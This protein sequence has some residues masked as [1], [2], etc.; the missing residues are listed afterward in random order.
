M[1]LVVEEADETIF[2]LEIINDTNMLNSKILQAFIIEGNEILS[3]V[4]K[5]RKTAGEKLS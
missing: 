3:I 4:A 2:W 5:T 1:C